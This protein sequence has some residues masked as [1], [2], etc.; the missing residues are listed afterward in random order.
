MQ[1]LSSFFGLFFAILLLGLVACETGED[2][3]GKA[4]VLR[5]ESTTL[6]VGGDG[7]RNI[8]GYSVENGVR[9]RKPEVHSDVEW[10]TNIMV[11]D[12]HIEFMVE[13]SD[14]NE[15]RFGRLIVS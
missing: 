4:P 14:V 7:G 15:E 2:I 6:T 11:G 5:L 1:R 12:T 13:K 9:G 10:I 3:T 8:V